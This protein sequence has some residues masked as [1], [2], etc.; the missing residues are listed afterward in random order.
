LWLYDQ[1]AVHDVLVL[2]QAALRASHV[3]IVD[4]FL[5]PNFPFKV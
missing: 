1:R 4:A 2:H 3:C 5:T